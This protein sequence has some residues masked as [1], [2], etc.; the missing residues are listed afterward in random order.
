MP[1]LALVASFVVVLTGCPS[2]P[3]SQKPVTCT[4]PAV[5]CGSTCVDLA[6]DE[7][8]C[9]TCDTVCNAGQV[10]VAR[11]CTCTAP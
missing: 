10:C 8:H 4:A 1:R 3:P 11:L 7:A 2:D 6:T 5:A 9:G